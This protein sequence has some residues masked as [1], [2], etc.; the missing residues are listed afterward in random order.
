MIIHK[1]ARTSPGRVYFQNGNIS[2]SQYTLHQAKGDAKAGHRKSGYLLKRSEGRLRNVWQRR[3]CEVRDGFLKISHA[4]ENKAP[5]QVNLLTCQMKPVLEDR[6][7]FDVVSYNRTYHF[8][9]ETEVNKEEWMSVLLN[10]KEVSLN[11][12]FE[13]NGKTS[14][15]QGLVE[16]QQTLVNYI[17][18][19]PSNNQCCDCGGNSDVTWL[20]VNFGVIVCIECSGIHREMGVHITKIQSLTLD[21]IGTSQLLVSRTMSNERFNK[22][23]EATSHRKL[24]PAS[25]MEERK[26][27]IRAKYSDRAY[28]QSYCS[29]ARELYAELEAAVDNHSLEDLLQASAECHLLG[30]DL[31]D[32]LPNSEFQETSLHHAISQETGGS[33]HIVDFLVQNSS[34]LDR[35]TKEGNT[36]LHYCVIQNQPE[37]MR[38]LLRSGASAD[39]PNNN[40][41]TPLNIARERG[42]HLCEELVSG[43]FTQFSHQIKLTHFTAASRSRSE[44]DNV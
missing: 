38:L 4:D 2:T 10:S 42:Y 27:Y 34:S 22:I 29:S 30:C 13:D 31:T 7:C 20:A 18:N 43:R 25:T 19:I 16:F 28:V 23:M 3:R 21:N 14:E 44:E 41:K 11:R 33:L 32:P 35:K 39:L 9:A 5:S 26:A 8:Q 37:A 24:V 12:A 15:N 40:G 1:K 6:L 36:P 17:R